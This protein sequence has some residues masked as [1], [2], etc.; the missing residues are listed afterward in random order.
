MS[1]KL[2]HCGCKVDTHGNKKAAEF[3]DAQYGAGMRLANEG[4]KI[5]CRCTVC[6]KS[7]PRK[8]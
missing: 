6:G 2:I 4:I 7:V 8:S 1:V 5:D 3:Q